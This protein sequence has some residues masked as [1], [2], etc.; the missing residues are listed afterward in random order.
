MPAWINQSNWNL[1]LA[2]TGLAVEIFVGAFAIGAVFGVVFALIRVSVRSGPLRVVPVLL[3]FH[4]AASRGIPMLVQLLFVAYAPGL[5]GIHT[6]AFVGAFIALSSFATASIEEIVRAAVGSVSEGQWQ[7][8]RALGM[9][10]RPMMQW[11]IAPQATRLVVPPLIG[12]A[13]QLLKATSIASVIGLLELT[14]AATILATRTYNPLGSYL[15]MALVYIV[16]MVP[17]V[18][19]GQ[20]AERRLRFAA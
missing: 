2:A 6:N 15:A 13:A 16:L 9:G 18:F 5:L 1:V 20:I 7:A 4:A 8:A 14:Q 3:Q 12:F 19:I 17:I 10:Y 11:I